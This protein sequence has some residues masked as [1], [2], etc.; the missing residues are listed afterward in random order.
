MSTE[1]TRYPVNYICSY[2]YNRLGNGHSHTFVR[3]V[4]DLNGWPIFQPFV[5]ISVVLISKHDDKAR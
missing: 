2:Q 3:G 5:G 4:I 1:T